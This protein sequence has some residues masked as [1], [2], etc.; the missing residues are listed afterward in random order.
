M[1][2]LSIFSANSFYFLLEGPVFWISVLI[3]ITGVVF[4]AG[5]ML[6]LTRKR[7]A[8]LPAAVIGVK[9]HRPSLT[10]NA[11]SLLLG[12]KGSLLWDNRIL[13]AVS[14][15]FHICFLVLPFF[16]SAHNVLL[17]EAFGV[18]LPSLPPAAVDTMIWTFLGCVLFFLLR[19]VLVARVRA[20]TTLGDYLFL[21]LAA[22]PFVTGYFAHHHI[23]N[24]HAM[25]V[26]HIASAE[27]VLIL[28]P[29]TRF[30]H[31]IF[32]FI[33]RFGVAGQYSFGQPG[34]VWQ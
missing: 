32:F 29:F 13:A 31:M 28:I 20:I 19:R 33:G 34:R 4:Q 8:S 26:L 23:L 6:S 12:I 1:S 21:L 16:I 15:I 24:S 18:S 30:V 3:F 25:T 11:R 27:L 9:R 14:I 22:A 5:Q 17:R 2:S 7:A 10:Q